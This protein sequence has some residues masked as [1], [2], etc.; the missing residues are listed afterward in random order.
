VGRPPRIT[1]AR[2][3]FLLLAVLP[4]VGCR[5]AAAPSQS[6]GDDPGQAAAGTTSF[7]M[8]LGG[9]KRTYLLHIPARPR[10]PAPLLI[11]LHGGGGDGKEMDRLTGFFDLA[12]RQG[13]VVAAPDGIG[14][15]WNDG[16][17]ETAS[18]AKQADDIG[19]LRSLMDRIARQ[20]SIDAKAIFVV[21]M[22]NGAIMTGRVACE[23][24]DRVAAVAQVAGTASVEVADTCHPASPIPLLEIHGTAD[25]LVPY[26]GGTVAAQLG[27]RGDVVS[28]DSWARSWVANDECTGDPTMSS[29]GSDTTIRSWHGRTGRSDV[30]FYR[31]AGAG[32]TWPDGPQ[33]L[34][35][36]IIGS[37]SR[38]FDASE[39]IWAFL[40]SHGRS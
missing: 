25:P 39:T 35:K 26:E 8:D 27:G 4:V 21:G 20:T 30:V 34:P 33:Y 6:S 11:E 38:S 1:T 9:L 16:R 37:T 40:S 7:S 36:A 31:V 24:A 13:F 18:S 12:D 17:A 2:A 23:L 22:S 29:L 15:S 5:G 14:H 19:F 3:L 32:H 10:R 28:V